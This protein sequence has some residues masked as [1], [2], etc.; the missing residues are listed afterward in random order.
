MKEL[1]LSNSAI[2]ENIAVSLSYRDLAN[3]NPIY[4]LEK[5]L[6]RSKGGNHMCDMKKLYYSIRD[7][8]RG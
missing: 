5:T 1:Q 7:W 6:K 2:E 3:E 8:S 4:K